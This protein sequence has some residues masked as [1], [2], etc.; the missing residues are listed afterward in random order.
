MGSALLILILAAQ[1]WSDG[2]CI[3]NQT[4]SDTVEC[5]RAGVHEAMWTLHIDEGSVRHC[6][7]HGEPGRLCARLGGLPAVMGG[8]ID[9]AR[10]G[11]E[12]PECGRARSKL[13]GTFR[14][15]TRVQPTS[16]DFDSSF[17][18]FSWGSVSSELA[19][20]AWVRPA[21]PTRCN[22]TSTKGG[23]M[24]MS[25][26]RYG[27]RATQLCWTGLVTM[28]SFGRHS[29]PTCG[30]PDRFAPLPRRVL[31]LDGGN[32]RASVITAHTAPAQSV[33]A[34]EVVNVSIVR[35]MLELVTPSP[36]GRDPPASPTLETFQVSATLVH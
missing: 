23:M 13:G 11:G 27:H 31:V 18:K 5:V 9:S 2:I 12:R 33:T 26:T 22:L 1:D 21:I 30:K 25:V 8:R 24:S 19:T 4:L 14:I 16:A 20:L 34:L 6:Y 17:T 7:R 3:H 36:Y 10:C 15:S 28:V 29:G 32:D 35:D